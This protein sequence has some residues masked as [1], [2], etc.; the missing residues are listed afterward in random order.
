MARIYEREVDE[1]VLRNL[2]RNPHFLSVFLREL[3]LTEV[4][5]HLVP[6]YPQT[7]HKA[8]SGSID[9][10]IHLESSLVLLVENK[11][12]AGYSTTRSGLGQTTRY[13]RS[14][15]TIKEGGIDARAV[16]LAPRVYRQSTKALGDFDAYVDYETLRPSL[17]GEDLAL[18]EAA[19]L[20]A[21]KPYEPEPNIFSAEFFEGYQKFVLSQF[22]QLVLKDNPNASGVRPT[23]SHTIYFDVERTLVGYPQL[24]AVR[25]SVQCWD[26]TASSAS[27]KIMIGDWGAYCSQLTVPLSLDE[28]GAYLRPAG[29]SLGIVI[30]TPRMDTQM[31]INDQLSEVVEGLEAALKLQYWWAENSDIISEWRTRILEIQSVPR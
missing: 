19:I 25:M 7:K 30:D 2:R 26:S 1:L 23:G 28:I 6:V 29:K 8:D 17:N 27:V 18:M 22:S 4:P 9:F 5:L 11:I 31:S 21:S 16:L 10:E 12:D 24:P 20:Q 14:C 15:S 3:G 13:K